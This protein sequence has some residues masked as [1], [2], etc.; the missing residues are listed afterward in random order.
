MKKL[1]KH[2]ILFLLLVVVGSDIQAVPA[3]PYPVKITQP[4]GTTLTIRLKGD[5]FH[6][7]TETEDG[8]MVIKNSKG[9]FNYATRDINGKIIE[10]QVKANNVTSRSNSEK[11]FV[12]G[13]ELNVP[14]VEFY[15]QMRARRAQPSAVSTQKR[16]YPSTGTPRSLV[17]LVNFSDL[18]YVTPNPK[19]AFTALLNEQGYSAN[20]GTGSARDY[21]I[22]NSMGK[23]SPQFDVVGPV[24]LPQRMS[25]YGDNNDN[26]ND[27]NPVQMV[28]DACKAAD[29]AGVDFSA[30]DVDNN[31]IVDN[32]FIYF[33]GHNEAE[34]ASDSTVWPHRW[35]IYPTSIYNGGNYSGTASSVTFDGKRVE[36][37]AC[38]SELKGQSGTSMAGIGTF[39]HEFGHVI[40]LA[41]MYATNG[42]THHTLS[43]W[44]IMDGGAYLNSGR[45]PP[46]YNTF[47]RFQLGYITPTLLANP[48]DIM[49][50]PLTTH[51]EAYL[52]SST[53]THNLN[54]SN[55]SPTEYFLLE[56]RQKIGW[57]AYLP[58]HGM[59]IY[60]IYYNRNDWNYNQPNNDPSKMGVDIIEA[61]RITGNSTLAGDPFPGTSN[62]KSYIPTLRSGTILDKP[63][64][65]IS[66]IEKKIIFKFKGGENIPIISIES[67]MTQFNTVLDTPSEIQSLQVSGQ[68][69][70]SDIEISLSLKEH[71]EIKKE[72]NPEISWS[73][74]VILSPVDSIVGLTNILIRYNPTEPSYKFTHS[75]ILTISTTNLDPVTI[76]LSGQS[77]RPIYVVP[78]VATQAAENTYKSFIAKWEPVF[79]AT[80]YYLTVT[81]A[82]E[83]GVMTPLLTDKWLTT[84]SDTLYYLISDRDY[85][86]K[87]KAS[88]KNTV[89]GYENITE[90]SN[91]ISVRTQ[92]YP[93]DK[94]LR[95]VVNK[96]NVK[97]FVPSKEESPTA[98]TDNEII[99]VFNTL[100]QKVKSYRAESDILD[101]SDLPKGI[102]FIIQAGKYRTKVIL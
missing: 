21:F 67:K 41:D 77:T 42:A 92:P 72:S 33:A 31:G 14:N 40:G 36:D 81:Q 90:Y 63:I 51:N 39:T 24:T 102:I 80:G 6:H 83:N 28:V 56:N 76:N 64:T 85:A 35:G 82:D 43:Y 7:Y 68:K 94:E 25:F 46:A 10:T 4:D 9:I 3:Y 30:Y 44:N 98:P 12:S 69:V 66:E 18:S 78:P 2:T 48:A 87:V 52:I 47:E 74:S 99:H 37:Y 5:E 84:T 32:V 89:N 19:E 23:F 71:F 20:G 73:K 79:D 65:S 27:K 16:V 29:E 88:D 54:A 26:D 95:V 22:D 34:H 11:L 59:L 93:F 1:F 86:Y 61:D 91:T 45:T 62:A 38:T 57:D 17:I 49:L 8:Y 53:D 101:I 100:G 96:G 70:I 58:G 97:V 75:D 50:N 60:R 55:P 15:Q 13:L